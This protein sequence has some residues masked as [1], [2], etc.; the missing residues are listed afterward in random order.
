MTNLFK[1]VNYLHTQGYIHRDIKP[2]NILF[3]E[4]NNMNSLKIVD[5]GLSKKYNWEQLDMSD[6]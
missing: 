5:L 1:G 2:D 6:I 3:A 4:S